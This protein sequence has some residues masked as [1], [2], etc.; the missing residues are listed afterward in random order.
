MLS[1]VESDSLCG[2]RFRSA[3]PRWWGTIYGKPMG[4]GR[5]TPNCSTNMGPI[6][7][8]MHQNEKQ[9]ALVGQECK[10]ESYYFP[11]QY[12]HVRNHF[13]YTFFGL[14][15]GTTKDQV[16]KCLSDWNKG[17]DGILDLSKAY[18]LKPG[19]GAGW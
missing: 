19:T 2:R 8:H 14:E 13:P 12:N 6:P 17:D 4:V 15:P 1:F 10:P 9:A 7:H 18:R 3:V 16:R 11:P 5:S